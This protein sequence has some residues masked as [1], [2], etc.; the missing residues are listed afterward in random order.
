MCHTA[1]WWNKRHYLLTEVSA[2]QS[3]IY[4]QDDI[5]AEEDPFGF[6]RQ[7]NTAPDDEIVNE[8]FQIR[9]TSE[10]WPDAQSITLVISYVILKAFLKASHCSCLVNW[11][12]LIV[13]NEDVKYGLRME[14]ASHLAQ[15]LT[16]A[17]L[18]RLTR[19]QIYWSVNRLT[20]AVTPR[21]E[22]LLLSCC[23]ELK[24]VNLGL[25]LAVKVFT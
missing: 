16:G 3:V 15:G 17:A 19:D 24:M 18:A 6:P 23:H 12:K 10:H 22:T 25:S 13:H 7:P 11:P 2:K 5:S 9:W 4:R 1:S 8:K 14:R 20:A 21:K